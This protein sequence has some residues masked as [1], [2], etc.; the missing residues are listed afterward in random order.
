DGMRQQ[1]SFTPAETDEWLNEHIPYRIRALEGLEVYN[2]NGAV[3]G[4]LWIVFPSIFQSVL[5]Q[6]RLFLDF[7]GA[8]V[9]DGRLVSTGSERSTDVWID[10]F[11][12]DAIDVAILTSDERQLLERVY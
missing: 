7:L 6:C 2:Q 10:D 3:D 4:P 11:R 5:M 1:H 12:G 8:R 9:Q